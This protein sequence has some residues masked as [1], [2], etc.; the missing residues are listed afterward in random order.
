MSILQTILD[1]KARE[2]AAAREVES[3]AEVR[4]RARTGEVP[5]GF[6]RALRAASP[7]VIAEIKRASPSKGLIREDLDPVQAARAYQRGGATCLSVLTDS[8]FFG[9]HR[10]F[11]TSIRQSLDA[12]IPILRKEFIIDPY[13]V[14]ET[15]AIGADALL[16]IVA[17]LSAEAL[18]QLLTVAYEAGLDVLLEVHDERELEQ[19]ADVFAGLAP[20]IVDS[21]RLAIGINN[22]DLKTFAVDLTTTQRLTP[23]VKRLQPTGSEPFVVVAESGIFTAADM[24]LL[25]GYGADAFLIGESLVREGDPGVNLAA[26]RE[27]YRNGNQGVPE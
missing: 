10:D 9:G 15:R 13:Q 20:P 8:Q 24:L 14:W 25:N 3:E 7:A 23:L 17:A 22:R 26:L 27:Q 1:Q 18:A 12:P 19:T 21:R 4:A 6:I 5:R 16:L 11:V 2:I